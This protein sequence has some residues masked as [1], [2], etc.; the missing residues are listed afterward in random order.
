MKDRVQII[1]GQL[2]ILG[3]SEEHEG[4]E[5]SKKFYADIERMR[6]SV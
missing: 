6:T 3:V 2:G 1:E 4:V 5:T